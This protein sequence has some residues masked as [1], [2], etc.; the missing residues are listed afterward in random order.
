MTDANYYGAPET[1]WLDAWMNGSLEKNQRSLFQ[2]SINPTIPQFIF[3]W[4]RTA[5]FLLIVL[6]MGISRAANLSNPQ[7]DAYNCRI[8][9]E[10]FAGMYKFTGNTLLVETAQAITNMGSDTIKFYMGQN[11]SGQSGVTLTANITNLLTLARDEPSYRTVF[12]MPFRH[13]IFWAYP[14]A[15]SDEWWGN[16]YNATQGAKD[17]QEI[18]NLTH[19]LLTNYNNSGKTFYL[20][21]WEGDGYLD[22]NGWTTNPSSTTIQGMIGWLNNRQQAVDDA[23]AATAFTNVEVYNYAECNRVRDAMLNGPNNNERVINYVIPYVTNLDYLSYSSYDSQNLSSSD[24]YTTL[25]YMESMMPTNKLGSVPGPRMWIGEYGWG[26]YTTAVQEPLIRAYIQRLINWNYNG[27]CLPFILYWEMYSNYNPGGGTNYCLID[28][29]DNKVPAWYLH[30]FFYNDARMLVAQFLETN[31]RLPTDTEFTSLVS[32]LLNQPLSAPVAL[33]VANASAVVSTNDTATVSGTLAQG[34]YGDSEAA[35]WVYYGRQDGGTNPAAWEGGRFVGVNT[36]FNLHTFSVTL[37]NLVPQT[38]Y[39]F[40][41]YAANATTNA[42]APS[43]ALFSTMTL[44]PSDYG[45]SMKISFAGY[46]RGETLTNF[47]VLVNLSAGLPGFSYQQFASPN[48][49]DLRF[50]DASGVQLIPYEIDTWNTNGTSSIWVSVP[51]LSATNDFIRAYWGNPAA[52]NP[53]FYTTNGA[54]WLPSYDAVYH[55]DQS[56]SPYYDSTLQYPALTGNAPGLGPGMIGQAAAFSGS[57]Y[58]NAGAVN[59]GNAFTLSAW[60]N[61]SSAVAN[62][63][64]VWANGPGGYFTNEIALF[65]NDYNTG[66]GALILGTGD[67]TSGNQLE[68]ATNAVGFNQWHLVT[69][70]VNRSAGTAQLYVDG[71]LEASGTG[72]VTDFST[73]N[74]LELGRFTGG[75]FPFNGSIDEA[76]VQSGLCS[77]NWIWAS[78]T[79]VA[80]NGAL[81]NYSAVTQEPPLLTIGGGGN[82][83]TLLTWPASGVGFALYTTTNLTP[84]V[85]WTPATNQPALTSNQWQISLPAG[86]NSACFYRLKSQ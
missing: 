74:N 18:Y 9:T 3:R 17:Y 76:R 32:P 51:A 2:Q 16:G 45:S 25:N 4:G 29:Q 75:S 55:L 77:S 24:L 31:G 37:N 35:L 50:T 15:N 47:P 34:I 82:T 12:D 21:H 8:G 26:G 13:F 65:V 33:T 48:G 84:P 10:T 46:N 86:S 19:Y 6:G 71:A 61:V 80:S 20:G 78:Y 73:N 42:W 49:G 1:K 28:Y 23:K 7:V 11:T 58:L 62:I 22:V 83:G 57:Q 36:N 85:V 64:G 43:S 70:A 60:V 53:P 56:G 63:Q 14:F 54:V 40:R 67:G 68:T 69:A 39:F 79:T 66:D 38:N 81:E 30:N 44:N 27:Q 72:V 5:L 59:L 52:A 41:F